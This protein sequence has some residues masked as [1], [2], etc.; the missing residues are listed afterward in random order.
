MRLSTPGEYRVVLFANDGFYALAEHTI[1]VTNWT[2][3]CTGGCTSNHC[4]ILIE[5]SNKLQQLIVVSVDVNRVRAILRQVSVS[6]HQD[7]SGTT[8]RSAAAGFRS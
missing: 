7:T 4:V 8:V 6:A 1:V 3:Q 5:M 2:S